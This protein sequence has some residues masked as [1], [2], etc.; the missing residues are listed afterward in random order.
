MQNANGLQPH[1]LAADKHN[2]K[3]RRQDSHRR[4]GQFLLLLGLSLALFSPREARAM[5]DKEAVDV[6]IDILVTAGNSLGVPLDATTV[7]IVKD[8]VGCAVSKAGGDCVTNVVVARALEQMGVNNPVAREA[9]GCL[10]GGENAAKCFEKTA[11]SALPEEARPLATCIV[12]GGN[13]ADCTAKAAVAQI[14]PKVTEGMPKEVANAVTCVVG[15]K[16]VEQCGREMA[17]SLVGNCGGS[18]AAAQSCI[19]NALASQAGNPQAAAMVKCLGVSGD[20][21][22]SCASSVGQ[23]VLGPEARRQ[24]DEVNKTFAELDKIKARTGGESNPREYPQ[25]PLALYNILKIT[26]GVKE[27]D[28]GTII[29]Y[30]GSA[31]YQ[32]AAGIIINYFLPGMG[33]ILGPVA[34]GMIMN[35]TIAIQQGFDAIAGGDPVGFA[36]AAGEWYLTTYI[37]PTCSLIPPG[38]FRDATCGTVAKAINTIVG[39]AGD[40]AKA[41]LGVGEDFLRLI[42]VWDFVDGVASGIWNGIKDAVGAITGA[43]GDG[44][45]AIF[46]GG[47]EPKDKPPPPIPPAE[48]FANNMAGACIGKATARVIASRRNPKDRGDPDTS[49]VLE[50]CTKYY[51]PYV[52]MPQIAQLQCIKLVEGLNAMATAA[53]NNLTDAARALT[54]NPNA[55]PGSPASQGTAP[56]IF[57]AQVYAKNRTG[58]DGGDH[59]AGDLCSPDFWTK[60][61]AGY[62]RYC[63]NIIHTPMKDGTTRYPDSFK[64]GNVS[65]QAKLCPMP[66]YSGATEGACQTAL[67]EFTSAQA[68]KEAANPNL[69]KM[70]GPDSA[71]CKMQKQADGFNAAMAPDCDFFGVKVVSGGGKDIPLPR[72]IKCESLETKFPRNRTNPD[73]PIDTRV[74]KIPYNPKLDDGITVV[75]L[76]PGKQSSPVPGPLDPP[77]LERRD[78]P[79]PGVGVPQLPKFPGPGVGP[80]DGGL[81]PP[82]ASKGTPKNSG[83]AGSANSGGT[84]GYY[85]SRPIPKE[86]QKR[87]GNRA[88]APG[89]SAPPVNGPGTGG[90]YTSR[91]TGNSAM[92]R[93]GGLNTGSG[94][95]NAAGAGSGGVSLQRPQPGAPTAP[96]PGTKPPVVAAPSKPPA[97]NQG[98][99]GGAYTVDGRT[100][101][102]PVGGGGFNTSKGGGNPSTNKPPTANAG[103]KPPASSG[104]GFNDRMI[105]YG[106]CAG[107]GK[108]KEPVVR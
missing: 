11:M 12:G 86:E 28:I 43:I 21:A 1:S 34:A 103:S 30:G 62:G 87:I 70:V 67:Q 104:G 84:G 55:P 5:T 49:K 92:D 98:G 24:L 80:K 16:S 3:P 26:E 52:V 32:V 18:G 99:S 33:P 63:A 68:A 96:P 23:Q 90:A 38:G 41:I 7:K 58:D 108:P 57:L 71:L 22:R 8:V 20:A 37:V 61:S 59:G 50:E 97:G 85:L 78:W 69:P 17:G 64:A 36:Q 44:F 35:H 2:D 45:D 83:G 6:T 14:L 51:T 89:G 106:G 105:D 25:T 40:V 39:A 91:P 73:P 29:L 56:M 94:L 47:D 15:G 77:N 9:V 4:C 101:N 93:L 53:A 31:L 74:Q 46:G 48:Y 79:G 72:G 76:D 27:N 82:V 13:V 100:G 88:P 75:N 81:K 42:G 66:T 107:C 102:A 65:A 60:M 19:A 95:S 10:I 54:G